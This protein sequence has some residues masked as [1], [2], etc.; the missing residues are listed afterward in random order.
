VSGRIRAEEGFTLVELLAAMAVGM[1]VLLGLFSVLDSA[2]PASGRVADRVDAE[3][4][5]R[6]GVEQ[7]TRVL[8]AATC[9]WNGGTSGQ[10][11]FLSPFAAASESE[12]TFYADVGTAPAVQAGTTRPSRYQLRYDP[13]T[14]RVTQTVWRGSGTPPSM[15]FDDPSPEI[16]VL[17]TD[18]EPISGRPVF[19]YQAYDAAGTLQPLTAAPSVAAGDLP[20][21]ARVDL[22]LVARASRPSSYTGTS[23]TYEDAASVRIGSDFGSAATGGIGPRCR[24]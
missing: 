18:A 19:T 11:T 9:V 2:V 24:F 8:R 16:S 22:G 12:V 17:L 5:G 21:I 3:Q 14:K 4:R 6:V 13:A 20:R 15:T 23:A 7:M 10:P 1:I